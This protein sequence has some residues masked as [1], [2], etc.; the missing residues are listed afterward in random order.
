[1]SDTNVIRIPTRMW[2]EP[3]KHFLAWLF[4]TTVPTLDYVPATSARG[5]YE[6]SS[7]YQ[8]LYYAE[9]KKRED[10]A[11]EHS[12]KLSG[13]TYQPQH[14][15]TCTKCVHFWPCP[16]YK[17]AVERPDLEVVVRDKPKG[18]K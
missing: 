11:D 2:P 7:R 14:Y 16:S 5:A 17:W 3:W 9:V 8:E 15:F 4:R 6:E 1:M 18:A 13:R 10:L 12:P